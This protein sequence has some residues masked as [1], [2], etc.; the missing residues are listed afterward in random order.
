MTPEKIVRFEPITVANWKACI[1]LELDESQRDFVPS[2]LYSIAESQFYPEAR[3]LAIFNANDEM[4]GQMVGFVMYGRD[5]VSGKWKIFRLMIDR[6]HQGHG[7]GRSAM[8]QVMAEIKAKPDGNKILICYHQLNVVARQL[9]ASLGFVEESV[10]EQRV[11][12]ARWDGNP[13]LKN[14]KLWIA[15]DADSCG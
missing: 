10:N 11:V 1:A 4:I 5:G 2:N 7:Y 8:L 9:Y 6:Q 15:D 14:S 3:P 12:T 13:A